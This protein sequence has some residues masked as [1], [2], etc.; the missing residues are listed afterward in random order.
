MVLK[1]NDFNEYVGPASARQHI[2]ASF[3]NRPARALD[4]KTMPV[5]VGNHYLLDFTGPYELQLNSLQFILAI[6]CRRYHLLRVASFAIL[7]LF[8]SLPKPIHH[9]S[10]VLSLRLTPPRFPPPQR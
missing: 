10:Q 2:T 5:Q 8:K 6:R 9:D 3:A 1:S 7:L 4:A